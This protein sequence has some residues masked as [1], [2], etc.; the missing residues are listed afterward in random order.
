[1]KVSKE[2][3]DF[4]KE[5]EQY[6]DPIIFEMSIDKYGNRVVQSIT[7]TKY[8]KK[9]YL[10]GIVFDFDYNSDSYV[11][12]V[13]YNSLVAYGGSQDE[14]LYAMAYSIFEQWV[15]YSLTPENKLYPKEK[16]RKS[17]LEEIIIKEESLL[18]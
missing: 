1:M 10:T 16:D 18:P 4:L 7:S 8:H 15:T 9:L 3:E 6:T 17:L 13:S 2:F 5:E 12:A 11:W 14:A